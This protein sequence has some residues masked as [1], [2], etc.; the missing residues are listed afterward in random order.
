[1]TGA[2]ILDEV[3]RLMGQTGENRPVTK[4]MQWTESTYLNVILPAQELARRRL[5][6]AGRDKDTGNAVE[7]SD[8]VV[9]EVIHAEF[10]ADPNN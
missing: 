1:M 2:D 3:R 9:E 8:S 5:G 6:S 4:M 10:L 7:Y